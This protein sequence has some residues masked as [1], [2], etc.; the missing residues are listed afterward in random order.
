[1]FTLKANVCI[2]EKVHFKYSP[3]YIDFSNKQQYNKHAYPFKGIHITVKIICT[4]VYC[5][6]DAQELC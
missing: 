5:E 6:H 2:A 4:C 3:E 1:M